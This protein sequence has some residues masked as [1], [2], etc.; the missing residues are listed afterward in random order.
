MD[1]KEIFN[2]LINCHAN[3][4]QYIVFSVDGDT[5]FFGKDQDGN[6]VYMIPSTLQRATSFFQRTASLFFGFNQKCTFELNGI[7]ITRTVHILS[8]K[9]KDEDK[10][11][12]FIR[13]THAFTQT[14]RDND[15][16]YLAKLFSSLSTLF[17]KKI[18]VSDIELK[19]LFAELYAILN[20][21]EIGCDISFFW[22]SKKMMKFD[23]NFSEEKRLEIKSTIKSNR[24]HHFK[25]DQLLSELYDIKIVSIMLQKN[26]RGLSLGNVVERI[27][28]EYPEDYPL[29]MHV[30]SMIS[31]IDKERLF[32]VKYDEVYL[33]ENLRYFDA[34]KIPHFN[35]KTPEGVFNAEYDCALDNAESVSE[36]EIVRWIKEG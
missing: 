29:L 13:L 36:D 12:A 7:A 2:T 31:H 22:Q 27:H 21:K 4:S 1:N 25:H 9:E 24:S 8:C 34:K 3:D 30:E 15:Q 20:F 16:L 32:E 28:E 26:D 35:E 17:D 5:C 18:E 14:D 19:G 6:V 11:N 23:F 33:K 10:V